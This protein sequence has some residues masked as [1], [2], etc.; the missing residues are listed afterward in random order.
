LALSYALSLFLIYLILKFKDKDKKNNFKKSL[1]IGIILGLS[2]LLNMAVF[3]MTILIFACMLLFF[4]KQRVYILISI[5]LAGI[6]TLP[7]YLYIQSGGHSFP[8]F[9][10][11]GYLI[12]NLNASNFIHYWWQ[13]LGL[14]LIFIPLGFII[15]KKNEKKLL[16]SFF[17]LFV[18]GNI[19]QFSPEIAA[20]HKF[21]N[22]FVIVGAMF[23]AYFLEFLWKKINF[24]KPFIIIFA[25][26][27]IFSGI[28]D[29]FPI[30]ND[31]KITLSDYP[32]NKD[33]LWIKKNTSPNAVFLN[34]QYLY[35]NASLA[36]R[37]IF[38][39]WPYFA[40]SQGYNTDLRGHI[41]ASLFGS[42]NKKGLCMALKNNKVD[43]I[44]IN[45]NSLSD[46]NLPKVSTFLRFGLTP[47]YN[48]QKTNYKIYFV[49]RNC[50]NL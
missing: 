50:Q 16:I 35:D 8:P 11:P 27:M 40:W 14:N 46:P 1:I 23:S 28:I 6:I 3:M 39:G 12:T 42:Q 38:L 36:G 34:T 47:I 10:H 31:H 2:F 25:F 48:D 32:V 20:N 43:Y 24:L 17:S 21:F 26:L 5:I 19:F 49:A 30:F 18:I 33:I 29:F 41:T 44:E 9:I 45:E 13:N 7:Q 22:F 37:K 4:S 15:A